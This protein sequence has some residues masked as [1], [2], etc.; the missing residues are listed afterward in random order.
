MGTSK[1]R[2]TTEEKERR[3]TVRAQAAALR[4]NGGWDDNQR[5]YRECVDLLQQPGFILVLVDQPGMME[6]ITDRVTFQENMQ[7]LAKCTVTLTERLNLIYQ[8]HKD[9]HGD[10]KK[11]DDFAVSMSIYE[12]YMQFMEAHRSVIQ[13]VLSVV[14]E[15]THAA[16]LSLQAAAAKLH[17]QAQAQDP[18]DDTPIDVE[19]KKPTLRG[20]TSCIFTL[21]DASFQTPL[22]KD[23]S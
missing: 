10:C 11:P 12:Q 15:I 13:P 22:E 19:L 7:V 8:Q 20:A 16:E 2:L 17:Q 23:A 6:A 5:L 18:T 9:K 1:S 3:A 21:D 4:N 14:L